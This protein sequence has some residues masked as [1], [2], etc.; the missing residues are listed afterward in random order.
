VDKLS[1]HKSKMMRLKAS[2]LKL[3]A[4]YQRGLKASRVKKLANELD[5]DGLGVVTVAKRK[6][7]DYV[8]IDGQHRVAAL[9]FH[10][11][12]DWV[13]DCKVYEGLTIKDE[14]HMFRLLNKFDKPSPFDDF[15][16]GRV[17]GD[18]ECLAIDEIVQEAGLQ[19]SGSKRD[20]VLTCVRTLQKVYRMNGAAEGPEVLA[21]TLEIV[22]AA[23]GSERSAMDGNVIEAVA[24]FLAAYGE[25]ANTSS[26]VKK[27]AKLPGGPAGFVGRAKSMRDLKKGTIP[28]LGAEM[29]VALYNKGRR[30]GALAEL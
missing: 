1:S 19:V 2:T 8:V 10:G 23:W 25:E 30:T 26:L 16:A 7:G 22:K 11:F 9:E 15:H 3:A 28:R 6:N 13:L 18:K 29:L 17:Q 5:L 14:A 4:E 27:M 21:E 20:G 12:G 24:I